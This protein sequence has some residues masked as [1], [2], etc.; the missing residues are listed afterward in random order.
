MSKQKILFF[1][2]ALLCILL[3][4]K[5]EA[6]VPQAPHL[7]HLMIQKIKQT[8]GLVIHQPR[9]VMDVLDKAAGP[10]TKTETKTETKMV[11]LDEKLVYGFPGNFRSE[12]VSGTVS[13]FYVTSDSQFVKVA[14]GRIVS[15]IKSPVDFYTDPLLYRDYESLL[16]QLVVAGVDTQQVV[17]RR[18]A[19]TI[20]YFIGQ[21]DVNGQES[22][23]PV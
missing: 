19:D 16:K 11:G 18:L 9:N 4:G 20:C 3:A 1:S 5:G 22:S 7:L 14:D 13:R 2:V 17:F 21:P 6:F 8:A 12:I 10:E 23:G 15:E